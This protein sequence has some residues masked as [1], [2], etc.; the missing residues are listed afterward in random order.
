MAA[1]GVLRILAF[2]FLGYNIIQLCTT[3][4]VAFQDTF[5][6]GLTGF[7][8]QISNLIFTVIFWLTASL[9]LQ[10]YSVVWIIGTAVGIV[11]GVGLLVGKYRHIFMKEKGE[12]KKILDSQKS[13]VV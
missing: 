2:Y 10:S 1:V 3:I 7:M 13:S 6:Q 8:Q 5:A 11:V 4:F 9:T 12:R